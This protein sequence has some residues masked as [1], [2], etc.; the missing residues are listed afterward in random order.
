MCFVGFNFMPNL[1]VILFNLLYPVF[2]VG[3][4]CKGCVIERDYVKT[5][6]IEDRIVFASSSRLSIPRN[7]ACALHMIGMQ[8]GWSQL[9]FVSSSRVRPS[10][11]TL[12]KHSVLPNCAI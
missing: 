4:Y 11:E 1:I 12:A 3:F 5:Q 10:R 9:C 6:A 7:D 8:R 2:I